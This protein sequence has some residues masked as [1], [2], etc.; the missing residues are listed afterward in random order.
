M[1]WQEQCKDM[2]G[3]TWQA[4]LSK[5]AKVSDRTVRYWST[6]KPIKQKVVN[7]IDKTYQI[8]RNE[9]E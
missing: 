2:F 6:G 9:N 1:N 7:K 3:K 8:W 4:Q 5:L